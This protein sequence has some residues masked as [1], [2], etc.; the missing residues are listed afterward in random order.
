MGNKSTIVWVILFLIAALWHVSCKNEAA[1]QS[2]KFLPNTNRFED[3]KDEID[4]A[5]AFAENIISAYQQTCIDFVVPSQYC[6]SFLFMKSRSISATLFHSSSSE[7]F[8]ALYLDS[9]NFFSVMSTDYPVQYYLIRRPLK[10]SVPSEDLKSILSKYNQDGGIMN[11]FTSGGG[12]HKIW[13]TESFGFP[14]GGV[15]WETS[16]YL[17]PA[18]SLL[19][20]FTGNYLSSKTGDTLSLTRGLGLLG[21]STSIKGWG[22]AA[23]P[24]G[25][26]MADQELKQYFLKSEK[27][28][29][30]IGEKNISES[31]AKKILF[32]SSTMTNE[33][34]P[35]FTNE[36]RSAKLS[37][38]QKIDSFILM[39]PKDFLRSDSGIVRIH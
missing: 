34:I 26:E 32:W 19:Y 4:T 3:E 9:A 16:K 29:Q 35:F 10:N 36:Y 31:A 39:H 37:D 27:F 20:C 6:D 5:I 21:K 24:I 38:K 18:D 1:F 2:V 14:T 25:I 23:E 33:V 28:R 11:I 15:I 8:L 22:F 30:L 12:F 13:I 7:F 17:T